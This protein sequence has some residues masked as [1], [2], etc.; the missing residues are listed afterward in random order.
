[1]FISVKDRYNNV[2]SLPLLPPLLET[3]VGG[4]DVVVAVLISTNSQGNASNKYWSH[5]TKTKTRKKIKIKDLKI[6]DDMGSKWKRLE[7]TVAFSGAEELEEVSWCRRR[8]REWWW[9][10]WMKGIDCRDSLVRQSP[11]CA[12]EDIERERRVRNKSSA[13]TVSLFSMCCEF[14]SSETH[15]HAVRQAKHRAYTWKEGG[16]E[17][18]KT[19][20]KR[21]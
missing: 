4:D 19:T 8:G 21:N 18:D 15:K 20:T 3:A 5:C 12:R 9:K 10:E 16:R 11:W 1:M 14:F 2:L 7:E 17:K 13:K 6:K